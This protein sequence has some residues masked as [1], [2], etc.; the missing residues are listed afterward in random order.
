MK[1]LHTFPDHAL[2]DK[3]ALAEYQQVTPLAHLL[4]ARRAGVRM[5]TP[6]TM[7]N[8]G[9]QA[10]R[11]LMNMSVGAYSGARGIAKADETNAKAN[12]TTIHL[13]MASP[14]C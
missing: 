6:F 14:P 11:T 5:Q 13:I 2:E 4:A 10:L 12:T 7:C 9:P 1:P 8:P 3:Q